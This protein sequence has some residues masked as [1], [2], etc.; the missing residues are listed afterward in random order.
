MWFKADHTWKMPKV[1]IRVR[2]D[3]YASFSSPLG[4][5]LTEIF[6]E[7]LQELLSEYSYYADCAGLSFKVEL[8][9]GG[10][11]LR[12]SGKYEFGAFFL[13]LFC[14]FFFLGKIM[15]HHLLGR[16]PTQNWAAHLPRNG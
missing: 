4:V 6:I 14:S 16:L 5:A 13:P 12:F 10:L 8:S 3:S 15:C 2:L 9:K 7:C 11:L 1:N